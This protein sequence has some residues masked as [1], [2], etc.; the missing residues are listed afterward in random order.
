VAVGRI[1]R[2]CE[3]GLCAALFAGPASANTPSEAL[4]SRYVSAR[5]AEISQQDRTALDGY[6]K[7]YR[8]A[9]ASGILADRMFD[10][11]I[12]AGN[13]ATAVR[14]AGA[15]ELKNG[16]SSETALLLF[17]DAWRS[18]NWQMA[19]VAAD[20]LSSSGNLGFVA[21]ILKS[22]VRVAQGKSPDLPD[23]DAEADGFYAYYSADQR[24]YLDLASNKFA[25][26]KL[27]L[28]AIAR[29]P[30]D[31]VRDVM[32]AGA[33]TL[34]GNN[35]DLIF[36]EALMRSATGSTE[37]LLPRSGKMPADRGLSALYARAASALIEQEMPRE[38]LVLAR[39]A[40]WISPSQPNVRLSL[41][42]ALHAS[43]LTDEALRSLE[44]APVK[45]PYGVALL[46]SRI[47]ILIAVGDI[48]RAQTVITEAAKAAP[49]SVATKLLL[50][51]VQQAAN[52]MPLVT[53][54][55]REII[56]SEDFAGLPPRQQANYRLLL[57]SALDQGGDWP[58][59]R[60][61]LE[62]ALRVD[63]NNA[64]ALNQLGYA[65]L[66]RSAELEYAASLVQR[67]YNLAPTSSAITD[68]LGW[69]YFLQGKAKEA[70][71]YLEKA[72]KDAGTDSAINEHLGDVYWSLGR[73]KDARYAWKVAH[74]G[75]DGASAD[76]LLRKID[77]GLAGSTR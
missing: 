33:E 12:R 59:A 18:K 3:F 8:Q 43:G 65:L 31:H 51:R 6:V 20:E 28:R 58:S 61:E 36:A 25:S 14:A 38:G 5:L 40:S 75:S 27:G 35:A 21:P 45:S 47:D 52:N 62:K 63:P 10:T 4:V 41:A 26:A 76:R 39:I 69:S 11:A 23:A 15:K 37:A 7:L 22:W 56:R 16:L 44:N 66:E 74:Q 50:A 19:G 57:A 77:M 46:E 68:S 42:S 2:I 60:G 54:T 48:A 24:I 71:T 29:Q 1:I 73:R 49:R 17:A 70:L 55:Y 13:M 32:I 30:G 72:A 53:S 64:Q 34:A 9:S 67:A